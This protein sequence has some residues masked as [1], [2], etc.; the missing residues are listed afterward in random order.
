[1][2]ISVFGGRMSGTAWKQFF[3]LRLLGICIPSP[4]WGV[5]TEAIYPIFCPP[6]KEFPEN[7]SVIMAEL[8]SGGSVIF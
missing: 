2:L 1:M 5:W 8:L 6:Q 3:V 4:R 7:G